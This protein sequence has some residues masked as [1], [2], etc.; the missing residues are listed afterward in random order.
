[1]NSDRSPKFQKHSKIET[2]KNTWTENKLN[3]NDIICA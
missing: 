1:M 3:N 2:N